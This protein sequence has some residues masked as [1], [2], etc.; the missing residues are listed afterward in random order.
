LNLIILGNKNQEL[1]KSTWYNSD[2]TLFVFYISTFNNKNNRTSIKKY[3][4]ESSIPKLIE[5]TKIEYKYD[6]KGNLIEDKY[7]LNEKTTW[8]NRF[9]IKYV[10]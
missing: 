10:R 3:R 2:D 6:K 1:N 5:D 7:I 4:I 9:K 8:I